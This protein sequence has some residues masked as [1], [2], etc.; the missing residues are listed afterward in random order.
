MSRATRAAISLRLKRFRLASSAVMAPSSRL[1]AWR[2]VD[3]HDPLHEYSRGDDRLRVE[4][5]DLHHLAHLGDGELCRHGHDR[6]EV[7]RRLAVDEVAPTVTLVRLD[8]GHVGMNGELQHIITAM[9]AARL[10]IAG[11]KRAVAG[12]RVEGANPRTRGTD[13]FGQVALRH[14][15]EFDLAG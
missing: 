6:P 8:Q 14:H 12:R 7:A 9:D 3:A 2:A 10:A 4:R 5:A 13:A 15:L 11:Q 1:L